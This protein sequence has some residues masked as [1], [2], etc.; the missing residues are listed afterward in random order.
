MKDRFSAQSN[1]YAKYRPAYPAAF[2]S[3]L[4]TIVPSMEN[5][6]DCG[7][8]NGQVAAALADFYTTVYATDISRQQLNNAVQK[9]NIIYSQQQ[10]EQTNF[11]DQFFDLIVVAQA[12]HWFHFDEFYAEVNRT[13]KNN[14]LLVVLGY[15]KLE[16]NKELDEMILD[17]YRNIIG[18]Y[19]D[20]ERTYID[21]QYQ[22]IP[23]PFE[24]LKVPAFAHSVLWTFDQLIGYFNTWSAVKH[25][26]K[27]HG[28]NPVDQLSSRL[29]KSWGKSET[30]PVNF[31]L[32]ARIGKI[33]NA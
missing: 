4:K 27:E 28:I 26:I 1:L 23:F 17:F 3:Y 20:K 18:P 31:P 12:I 6:W 21:E 29:K 25:Y 8:G 14:A 32:F 2:F 5:A 19:W 9:K 30:V 16:I 33:N 10:A 24:E 22:T 13:A 7:T 11:P 15:G